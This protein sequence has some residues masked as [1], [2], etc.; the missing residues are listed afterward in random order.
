[1]TQGSPNGQAAGPHTEAEHGTDHGPAHPWMTCLAPMV[2]FL[3]IGFA[4]P[5]REGGGLA[6][7]IG[8]GY[9]GY[10]FIYS[11]RVAATILLLASCWPSLRGWLG[12]PSWWPPIVGLLLVVPW[13]VLSSLQRDA[14]WLMGGTER[15]GFD[16]FT[17]YGEDAAR[18]TAYLALRGLGLVVVV[19]IIEE[20]F[21]RGFLMRFVIREQ[22]WTVPFGALTAG[23]AA[24]CAIYAAGSHPPELAAAVVWFGAITGI[25]VATRRPIDCITAHA[26][27]NL[28]LGAWVL[29]TGNWWLL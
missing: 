14:G 24:T 11:I 12:R 13:I 15:A 10:P 29:A 7:L 26:A 1:M 21:L 6:G 8:L 27:T 5:S 23:A 16:P 3:A 17:E 18:S 22:F 28:A 19:P 4:E 20:I 2:V 9:E 25:A